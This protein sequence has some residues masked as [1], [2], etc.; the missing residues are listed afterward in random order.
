[1]L[2]CTYD[3]F[4]NSSSVNIGSTT[5]ASYEYNENNGK[6]K[7]IN[8][9]NGFSVEYVYNRLELLAEIWYTENGVRALAYSYE[10]TDD[11]QVYKF[12]DNRSGRAAPLFGH[13]GGGTQWWIAV[14]G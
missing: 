8:Y 6:I 14:F 9:G 10:Y 2:S 11:G 7:K 5:L 13:S 1:M 3:A 12:T 4:G